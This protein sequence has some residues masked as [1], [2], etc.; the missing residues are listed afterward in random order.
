MI[1]EPGSYYICTEMSPRCYVIQKISAKNIQSVC[2]SLNKAYNEAAAAAGLS[3]DNSLLFGA[4]GQT[5]VDPNGTP[6]DMESASAGYTTGALP[7]PPLPLPYWFSQECESH[8]NTLTV[9]GGPPSAPAAAATAIASAS[10]M[11]ALAEEEGMA[12]GGGVD[13]TTATAVPSDDPDNAHFLVQPLRTINDTTDGAVCAH[14]NCDDNVL[15]PAEIA[16]P[17]VVITDTAETDKNS[18]VEPPALSLGN[19]VDDNVAG[20]FDELV[21]GGS[22][23]SQAATGRSTSAVAISPGIGSDSSTVVATASIGAGD[24]F[25]AKL[26][27]QLEWYFS[28]ENLTVDNY[29]RSQMDND[30]YVPVKTV[31]NFN[32]VKKMTTDLDLIVQLYRESSL[33]Q[34]DEKG[35]KVRPVHKRCTLILREI[36]EGTSQ[37]EVEQLFSSPKCPTIVSCEYAH[38]NSWYINFECDEHAQ[39]AYVYLQKEVGTF[40]GRGIK[41]RIKTA[42]IPRVHTQPN[43]A[44]GFPNRAHPSVLPL[45]GTQLSFPGA[46]GSAPGNAVV[47][48]GSAASTPTVPPPF[49][50]PSDFGAGAG[51]LFAVS[52]DSASTST[53][54]L[55]AVGSAA[56]ATGAQPPPPPALV[57]ASPVITPPWP[58]AAAGPPQ[59]FDLGHILA[60]NG[61]QAQGTFRPSVHTVLLP[62][63]ALAPSPLSTAPPHHG[64]HQPHHFMEQ[65]NPRNK[66]N[67]NAGIGGA[68]GPPPPHPGAAAS[69]AYFYST[70]DRTVGGGVDYEPPGRLPRNAAGG[71]N[72]QPSSHV[73]NWGNVPLGSGP[74]SSGDHPPHFGSFKNRQNAAGGP[75]GSHEGPISGGSHH[76]PS[77]GSGSGGYS[78]RVPD[79][80]GG[81]GGYRSSPNVGGRGRGGYHY[82]AAHHASCPPNRGGDSGY[83]P[84]ADYWSSKNAKDK[85]QQQPSI[86]NSANI[87][88]GPGTNASSGPAQQITRKG[89]GGGNGGSSQL[90]T[91]LQQQSSR[92]KSSGSAAAGSAAAASAAV[93]TEFDFQPS[94]FPP[95]PAPKLAAENA[96]AV[97][98]S[99]TTSLTSLHLTTTSVGGSSVDERDRLPS[100]GNS[101]S[102]VVSTATT[103]I[104]AATSKP[105]ACAAAAAS[106]QRTET[107][108]RI[109]TGTAAVSQHWPKAGATAST[110]AADATSIVESAAEP[111]QHTTVVRPQRVV[112]TADKA[113]ATDSPVRL[114]TSGDAGVETREALVADAALSLPSE[115]RLTNGP[116]SS[117]MPTKPTTELPDSR[118]VPTAS[119]ATASA[120][121]VCQPSSNKLS[122]AAMAKH[123]VDKTTS[124]TTGVKTVVATAAIASATSKPT[125]VHKDTATTVAKSGQWSSAAAVSNHDCPTL[126][127]D[128][129]MINGEASVGAR[130]FGTGGGNRQL[131]RS[132]GSESPS[133]PFST[134]RKYQTQKPYARNFETT[135]AAATAST[136]NRPSPSHDV[137][138]SETTF[139]TSHV[140]SVEDQ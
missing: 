30:Q 91:A 51:G 107:F 63:P 28:R 27:R 49:T 98:A 19:I 119:S 117:A 118:N 86:R 16:G 75:H 71:R 122:Y 40:K 61:F 34:V 106:R 26:K 131:S 96:A 127:V 134:L 104:A 67:V 112:T 113:T 110:V 124:M 47:T 31:A 81:G 130:H 82:N 90:S 109:L 74:R 126:A 7:M 128:T 5:A 79:G 68:S 92:R 20:A 135:S 14:R 84:N 116:A 29:L 1:D 33:V 95:L 101:E 56:V 78:L 132:D 3:P 44:A 120:V 8:F 59:F 43:S 65:R 58:G 35:E 129:A 18:I 39:L 57:A 137:A 36:P 133:A 25:R 41:T 50:A 83:H 140:T 115:S 45:L 114:T 89:P 99:A 62:A 23:D 66:R 48:P 97:S 38:N 46:N 108:S 21:N 76:V 55:N 53:V 123:A 125:V 102:T 9:D 93:N 88:S 37:E 72:G 77:L 69:A 15:K 111:D 121:A 12:A 105:V 136:V 87:A 22:Y 103:T 2:E 70:G 60:L 13:E 85:Q 32:M 73:G 42:P 6:L 11:G 24:D 94:S 138:A 64:R 17:T 80:G 100:A 52:Q 139:R 54:S 10:C 4:G